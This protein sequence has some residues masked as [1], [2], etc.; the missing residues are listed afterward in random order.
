MNKVNIVLWLLTKQ[1]KDFITEHFKNNNLFNFNFVNK[2]AELQLFFKQ[3]TPD[4][5]IFELDGLHLSI[6]KQVY[7]TIKKHSPKTICYYILPDKDS[8]KILKLTPL[9]QYCD[10]V[11][12]QPL[13]EIFLTNIF[14]DI[15]DL[16]KFLEPSL[17][18]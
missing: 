13:S 12:F 2:A 17:K 18:E 6:F 14:D 7:A 10:G 4:L 16:K 9:T 3:N 15:S 8:L 1:S 11:I 5:V